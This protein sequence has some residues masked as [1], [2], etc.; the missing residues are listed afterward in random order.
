MARAATVAEVHRILEERSVEIAQRFHLP[1]VQFGVPVDG[2]G[3]RIR[4]SVPPGQHP[5]IP[6]QMEF[7]LN[8]DCVNVQMEVVDDYQE[9]E[10][11]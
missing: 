10:A 4:V 7:D 5:P 11:F 8:G 9:A 1:A 6:S 2:A 3:L